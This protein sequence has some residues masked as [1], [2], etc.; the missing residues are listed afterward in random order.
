[1]NIRLKPISAAR[2][3]IPQT[4][5]A[6]LTALQNIQPG[7]VI[8]YHS[9]KRGSWSTTSRK[10]F[11]DKVFMAAYRLY[12]SRRGICLQLKDK[13]HIRYLVLGTSK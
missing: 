9:V 2:I 4:S 5:E 3:I 7:Q 12:E 8:Q 13:T 11:Q 10:S 1:M 6:V